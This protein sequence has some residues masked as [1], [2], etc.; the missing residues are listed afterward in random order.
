MDQMPSPIAKAPMASHQDR[1]PAIVQTV[2]TED[3]GT[4]ALLAA[5]EDFRGYAEN[6]GL[7]ERK[8]RAQL[9]RQ[10]EDTVQDRL[11]RQV[12]SRVLTPEETARV[13]DRLAAR[14]VDPFSAA[15]EVL[16]RMGL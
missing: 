2:A 14:E 8:R 12:R 3:R 7:L 16:G 9:A 10:L 1:A 6:S 4:D 13:V 5:I 11:M 15:D